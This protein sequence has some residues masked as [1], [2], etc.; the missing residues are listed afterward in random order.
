MHEGEAEMRHKLGRRFLSL[1]SVRGVS[2][3]HE[4]RKMQV[5]EN[6]YIDTTEEVPAS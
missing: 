1:F 3:R 4:K 6:A 2:E 5:G